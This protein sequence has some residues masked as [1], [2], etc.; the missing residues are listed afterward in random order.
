MASTPRNCGREGGTVLAA[1]EDIDIVRA[2]NSQ[3]PTLA[4]GRVAAEA[5]DNSSRDGSGCKV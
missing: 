3:I 5:E 2:T 4:P 1:G